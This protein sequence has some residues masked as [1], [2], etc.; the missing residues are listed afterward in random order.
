ME[1]LLM[2]VPH[3]ARRRLREQLEIY[4]FQFKTP[5]TVFQKGRVALSGK[6]HHMPNYEHALWPTLTIVFIFRSV[7]SKTTSS[8]A[9]SSAFIGRRPAGC[10]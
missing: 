9:C 6:V 3:H 1:T 8:S 10:S 4:S 7:V 5:D 2:I